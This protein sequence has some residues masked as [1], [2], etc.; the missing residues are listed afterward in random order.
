VEF[1]YGVF[2]LDFDLLRSIGEGMDDI[3]QVFGELTQP[4]L[5]LLD[6]SDRR[7]PRLHSKV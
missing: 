7:K 1:G 6:E 2:E 4:L 3:L 5:A